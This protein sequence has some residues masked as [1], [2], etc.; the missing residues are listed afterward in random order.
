MEHTILHRGISRNQ[1]KHIE[2]NFHQK[3]VEHLETSMFN[4]QKW[5]NHVIFTSRNQANLDHF[6]TKHR[7]A[8]AHPSPSH[9]VVSRE[10]RRISTGDLGRQQQTNGARAVAR[11]VHH[12]HTLLRSRNITAYQGLLDVYI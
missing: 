8:P 11:G 3:D 2:T 7:S 12:L 9:Q 10:D 6:G 5:K 4:E 1:L